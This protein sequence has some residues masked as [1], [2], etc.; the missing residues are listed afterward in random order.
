M[1][2][3]TH[4][5]GHGFGPAPP[6]GWSRCQSQDSSVLWS[7][8]HRAELQGIWPEDSV[9]ASLTFCAQG[10]NLAF[11]DSCFNCAEVSHTEE[12][13]VLPEVGTCSHRETV[14]LDPP[15]YFFRSVYLPGWPGHT[16]AKWPLRTRVGHMVCLGTEQP[17][18]ASVHGRAHPGTEA[19]YVCAVICSVI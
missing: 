13:S 16:S 4:S 15:A 18:H 9:H 17:F 2:A 3:S 1:E 8:P 7:Q 10:I 6:A 19:G 14:I 11:Q 5:S 12:T